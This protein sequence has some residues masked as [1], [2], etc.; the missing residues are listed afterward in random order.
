MNL[1]P[2]YRENELEYALNK[3]GVKLLIMAE[4]FKTQDYYQMIFDLCP[5]LTRAAHGQIK[6]HR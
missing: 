3:V 1:N 5:E 6:S 2:A 4:S